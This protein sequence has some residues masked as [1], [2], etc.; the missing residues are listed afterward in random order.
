MIVNHIRGNHI[1]AVVS[2]IMLQSKSVIL[3]NRLQAENEKL[4]VAF[5][6]VLLFRTINTG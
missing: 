6:Y 4:V 5:K 1:D 2:L 3:F